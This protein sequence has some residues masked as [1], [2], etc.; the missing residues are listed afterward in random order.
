MIFSAVAAI[1]VCLAIPFFMVARLT[2]DDFDKYDAVSETWIA[3]HR[4]SCNQG[5]WN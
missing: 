2:R 4:A 3:E 5:H 1:L